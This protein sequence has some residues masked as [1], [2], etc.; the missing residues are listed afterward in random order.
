MI[1]KLLGTALLALAAVGAQAAP[2]ASGLPSGFTFQ[3]YTGTPT[4]GGGFVNTSSVLFWVDEAEVNGVKSWFIFMDPNG[5]QSVEG[6]I[7][8]DRPIIDV[9]TRTTDLASSRPTYGVDIDGDTLL[10][11]YTHEL[12]TGLELASTTPD[13]IN[14]TFGSNLLWI[15]WNASDPGDHIR[16]LTSNNVPEP[17][18]WALAGI[19]LA[20]LATARRRRSR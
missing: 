10:N 7:T 11:D 9:I 6:F 17:G 19:A 3:Q 4:V 5:S 2:V 20:G 8:F 13:S 14:W 12:G 1:R 16:V 18:S 15:S